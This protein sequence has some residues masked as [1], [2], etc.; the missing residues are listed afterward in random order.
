MM[1]VEAN[2]SRLE[3]CEDDEDDDGDDDD[4]PASSS[5]SRIGDVVVGAVVV[6]ESANAIAFNSRSAP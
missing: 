6:T 5:P 4:G 1:S 2:H 3:A